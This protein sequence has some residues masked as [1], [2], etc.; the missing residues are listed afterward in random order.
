MCIR[1]SRSDITPQV[2]R[3]EAH[4][5][6]QSGPSRLCYAG[7]VLHTRPRALSTSRSPI[8]VGAELYGVPGSEG[9]LEVISLMLDVLEQ[10]QVPDVHM[11]L[12]H[13]GIYRGLCQAAGVSGASEQQL[14]DALQRK[15]VDEIA[16]LTADLPTAERGWL[17]A[18][19]EL[20]GDATVLEQARQRLAG[21]PADVLQAL[22][23][24][25][26]LADSL[27]GRFPNVQLYFDLGELRGY[28]YHT[29]VV[30]SLIH[31]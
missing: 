16:E 12:G 28:H 10:A 8:Q 19:V 1:D 29:E 4:S 31:I 3:M 30:L 15:A 22:D 23:E 27:K 20:S 18:L 7:S 26:A 6:K 25:I 24:L 5:L 9:D 13:V 11:D 21:A 17:R 2:A 14:F